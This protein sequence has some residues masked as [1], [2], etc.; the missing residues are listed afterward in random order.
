MWRKEKHI[1]D[2]YWMIL[3]RKVDLYIPGTWYMADSHFVQN[4][5]CLLSMFQK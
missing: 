2:G 1:S 3:V 4:F 5:E